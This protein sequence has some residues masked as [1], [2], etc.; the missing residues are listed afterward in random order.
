MRGKD[1]G[2]ADGEAFDFRIRN[3]R[4]TDKIGFEP[5]DYSKAGVYGSAEWIEFAR[6]IRFVQCSRQRPVPQPLH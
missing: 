6:F 1:P 3:K 5:F 4:V 2:F